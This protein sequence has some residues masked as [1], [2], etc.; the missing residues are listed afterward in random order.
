MVHDGAGD[1]R[2]H[3]CG[4]DADYCAVQ[5]DAAAVGQG[6]P[7]SD[8]QAEDELPLDLEVRMKSLLNEARLGSRRAR[9]Y[10]GAL[11]QAFVSG[12][13]TPAD[14]EIALD[15]LNLYRTGSR[16]RSL[17]CAWLLGLPAVR[18][19]DC[20]RAAR[21]LR[22]VLRFDPATAPRDQR[23]AASRTLGRCILLAFFAAA[24]AYFIL[25]PRTPNLW[26]LSCY[27]GSAV[28]VG[29]CAAYH[30]ARR[31]RRCREVEGV[32]FFAALGLGRLGD[33]EAIE[34]LS[35]IWLGRNLEMARVASVS[36]RAIL[37][38]LT[39]EHYGWLGG[40]TVSNL[41]EMLTEQCRYRG[42]AP[43]NQCSFVVVLLNALE[44]IGDARAIPAISRAPQYWTDWAV[45]NAAA[46][47][48]AAIE[49]RLRRETA[50]TTLLRGARQPAVGNAELLRAAGGGQGGDPAEMLRAGI[51]ER[52]LSWPATKVAPDK[53]VVGLRRQGRQSAQ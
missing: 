46:Q 16:S 4:A 15:A 2:A 38:R 47:A 11:V 24:A 1:R 48:R 12:R 53:T 9:D 42:A 3:G 26:K 50:R 52:N 18:S 8:N 30:F 5:R 25:P 37:P 28:L 17:I 31:W 19:E 44:K 34:P 13:Y 10:P 6:K 23:E 33:V 41:A 29:S 43:E 49:E 21:A 45:R 7:V 40:A 14:F 39:P 27:V 20:A 51:A 36:L 35:S 22:E 32:H